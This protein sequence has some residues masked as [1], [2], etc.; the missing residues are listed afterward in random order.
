M[1]TSDDF[2]ELFDNILDMKQQSEIKEKC[3]RL[4]DSLSKLLCNYVFVHNNQEYYFTYPNQKLPEKV[5]KNL[6]T[7]SFLLETITNMNALNNDIQVSKF[8]T[9]NWS[10]LF[11]NVTYLSVCNNY[12]YVQINSGTIPI[13]KLTYAQNDSGVIK[14]YERK[15]I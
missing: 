4:T 9:N 12:E 7:N 10:L 1:S 2:A 13:R 11:N 15:I 6:Y 14:L 8:I 5:T 3:K